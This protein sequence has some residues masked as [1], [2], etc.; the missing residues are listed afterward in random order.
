MQNIINYLKK[1]IE[2]LEFEPQQEEIG[3]V[4]EVK[5]GTALIS[6]LQNVESLEI[7]KFKPSIKTNSE[8]NKTRRNEPA[9]VRS[10]LMKVADVIEA[11]P[12][13]LAATIWDS[14]CRLFN[15][16]SNLPMLI[17]N[18][19]IMKTTTLM[20]IINSIAPIYV[21]PILILSY[22]LHLSLCIRGLNHIQMRSLRIYLV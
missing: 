10:V 4:L 9:F 11:D 12:E 1:E 19:S 21:L 6:G 3:E 16:N 8:K 2:N 22:I 5:D 13:Q 15:I 17:A 14:T 7:I 20:D 18:T